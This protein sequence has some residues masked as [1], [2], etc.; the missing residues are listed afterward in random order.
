NGETYY[1]CNP[2]CKEKFDTDP[3]KYLDQKDEGQDQMKASFSERTVHLNLQVEG[4]H[5]AS[6]VA[7][8]EKAI[9]HLDGVE[10][11]SVNLMT[12]SV[13]LEFD[14]AKMGINDFKL[15]IENAGYKIQ[16][17]LTTSTLHIEGMHCAS[18]V[19]TVENALSGIEGVEQAAVNLATETARVRFHSEAVGFEDFTSAVDAVGYRVIPESEGAGSNNINADEIDRDQMKID[20]ARHKMMWVWGLTLPIILWMIP[21]MVFG[22]VIGGMTA[23]TMGMVGLAALTLFFPGRETLRS[24]WKSAVHLA[25]NM[26]VLIAMGTLGSLVTG[27]VALLHLLGLAPAFQNFAGVG[28]MIM[29]FHLT[30]R[31]I[32]IMAKGRAS[33]AIKKLLTLEAKEAAVERDGQEIKIPIRELAKGDIMIVRPGEKIPT[34]GVVVGGE[35]SVDESLATGESMP[36]NKRA[37]D[38]VIGATINKNGLLKIR[39]T[40][41]GKETFLSQ[42]IR[43]VEEAQGSKIPIQAFV[44][45]VT[46]VFVPIV[47]GVALLTLA[48][49]LLFPEFFK[50]IVVWASGFI[51]WVNPN[52][53]SVTFALFAT[54][55]VL[56]I[57]CPCALGL[58]TPT[59]LMVGSGKGAENGVLIRKGAAIQIM[60][61]VTTILLDKTGTITQGKPSVTLYYAASAEQGSEHPLG[62]AIVE[63]AKIRNIK[64]T[65]CIHFEA[66]N[67][68]GIQGEV[69]N[70]QV[71]VGSQKLLKEKGVAIPDG[72]LSQK[73]HLED[74]AKTAM[75]V[76]V[77]NQ[78][79][80]I[81][82]VADKVKAD[83]RD[84]IHV[85]K[86]YGL[87]PVMMTGDNERTAKAIAKEVGIDRVLA[88]V[89]PDAK[90][91]EVKKLQSRGEIVAMVGDGINDA[92]A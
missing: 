46:A 18:C 12:E 8:V 59:A 68:R 60:K 14:P 76:A 48:A 61:D 82:A 30:G 34:D 21:E 15:A 43:M 4:M 58:A 75:L 52:M 23:Y 37:G 86:S 63:H 57:A 19:A 25:P 2:G 31:Y 44:D 1:F 71:L 66:L 10:S 9:N 3:E 26:D 42:V 5:C 90:T 11:A 81:I 33:Q 47:L 32:E 55:A 45:K 7:T 39:A 69:K 73:A 84:A 85:L 49:W 78:L 56:V 64:L 70:K 89:L 36:V 65:E 16:N 74:E 28:A 29:A 88:N 83:S 41:I 24:A 77:K 20:T 13:S 79:M 27:V 91:N 67:G 92:P 80:G 35:S 53:S 40:K 51:P 17:K 6:C 62:Q 38:S 54:I 22:I 87:E 50:S 72:F